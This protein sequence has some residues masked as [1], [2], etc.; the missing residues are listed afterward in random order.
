M[1]VLQVVRHMNRAGVET[2]L[3]HVLRH[4]DR[5]QCQFD[6][7]VH[8]DREYAYSAEIRSLG[9]RLLPCTWPSAPAA[10]ARQFGAILK[11]CGP[12]DIVHSH[13]NHVVGN[14]ILRLAASHCVPRRI[15]HTHTARPPA[16]VPALLRLAD[17]VG[18]RLGSGATDRLAVSEVA[19]RASFGPG[20][21]RLPNTR[22]L[23][24]GI[25][26]TPFEEPIDRR[27]CRRQLGIDD[28]AFVIGQSAGSSARR[29][30]SS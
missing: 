26:L 21:S 4:I 9:G 13:L 29:T 16:S 27:A 18:R 20:W 14:W 24:C 15:L 7:L 28:E 1:R 3:M 19:A 30:T 17:L 12:Y 5:R 6:F 11:R 10:Y 23:Y 8:S 25:D 2:W 22:V